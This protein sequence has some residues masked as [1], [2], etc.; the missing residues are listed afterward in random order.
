MLMTS[1]LYTNPTKE[2]EIQPKKTNNIRLAFTVVVVISFFDT[3][4]IEQHD[5]GS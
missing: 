1:G 5:I 3:S 2:I 4:V